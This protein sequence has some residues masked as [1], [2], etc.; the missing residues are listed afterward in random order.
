MMADVTCRYREG[1]H[2]VSTTP[3]APAVRA[4]L[5]RLLSSEAFARSERARKLLRY[6]V[7][8]D[9]A[10]E[11]ERLKGFAIA[12][13][14]FGKEAD[15]DSATDAVVRVQAKR[16]RELLVQYYS[17]EGAAD[18][19][20]ITIPRGGYAPAYEVMVDCPS[21]VPSADEA[22][23]SDTSDIAADTGTPLPAP[24]RPRSS[25]ASVRQHLQLFW[26]A[27]ALV[28]V[29]LGILVFRHVDASPAS[30][31]DIASTSGDN[32][33]ETAGISS[34]QADT[35]P[36]VYITV[37][38]ENVETSRVASVLRTALSGFDTI[39]LIA[40]HRAES[41]EDT[42][43]FTFAVAPGPNPGSV[44]IELQNIA[45]GIVLLSR[46]LTPTD[47]EP[48]TLD[49]RIAD[50]VSTTVPLSGTIYSYIE[51][52]GLQHGLVSCLMLNHDYNMD[53]TEAKHRVA[54]QCFETLVKGGTKSVVA[55]SLLASLHLLAVTENYAYPPDATSA[56]ALIF[57][58]NAV[59]M[60]STSPYAHRA[61]GFVHS[62]IGDPVESIKWMRKAYE[63]NTYDLTMAAA[64]GY[65]LI[66]SGGYAEGT[67]I[68]QRAVQTSSAHP[69]WWD[70]GLFLGHF[71][72]G[73]MD[74]AARATGP[75]TTSKRW[76]Y[77]AARL[78]AAHHTGN[79]DAASDLAKKLVSGFPD[80]ASDPEAAFAAR[81]HPP[82]MTKKLVQALRAAGLHQPS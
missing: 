64:Y 4:T 60:G 75:L 77:L 45:T 10:G 80:I 18:P 12:I 26:M 43:H 29:M 11:A 52:N 33:A 7:E 58:Q 13:D 47:T 54:Y 53:P 55:Y 63:L 62:R 51:Q 30:D 66:L 22:Q 76:H 81:M 37:K 79:T 48:V 27:M 23:G 17:A 59:Q 49:D 19:I 39:D 35:P 9:L 1:R 78:I 74:E 14:V 24:G 2:L 41:H 36:A 56:Q 28:I 57:V 6:L 73:H 46:V 20:R 71:M 70:Y 34:V 5:E 21:D 67:P 82:D 38:A 72:L 61:Y 65:A 25:G 32:T 15:F 31:T 68:M 40:H 8:R 42:T 50:I 3:A 16:L 69:G 44:V